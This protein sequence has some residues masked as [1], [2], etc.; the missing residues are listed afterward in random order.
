MKKILLLLF[1]VSC[2]F[3]VSAQKSTQ[4]EYAVSP[5][6][7]VAGSF[8]FAIYHKN[9]VTDYG[10]QRKVLYSA[11]GLLGFDWGLPHG[12][13]LFQY[14][15]LISNNDFNYNNSYGLVFKSLALD[16]PCVIGYAYRIND[17]YSVS[18]SG[19]YVTKYIF[20]FNDGHTQNKDKLFAYGMYGAIGFCYHASPHFTLRVEPFFEYFWMSQAH[21]DIY[22]CMAPAIIGL[23]MGLKYNILKMK[24]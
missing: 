6:I 10:I 11:G 23:K 22:D 8:N 15:F 17:N 20:K 7:E 12:T 4:R 21:H 18:F 24:Q 14:G 9:V 19:G 2:V 16:M 13:F 1:C 5:T 3:S